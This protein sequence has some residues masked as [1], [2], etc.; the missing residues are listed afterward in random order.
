MLVTDA[1]SDCSLLECVLGRTFGCLEGGLGTTVAW[2]ADFDTQYW[3]FVEKTEPQQ[4]FQISVSTLDGPINDSCEKAQIVAVGES[5]EGSNLFGDVL[6][7]PGLYC[8][9]VIA[10]G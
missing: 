8:N 6:D 1:G 3:L 9:E 5:F 10:V 4:E 7:G 2:N